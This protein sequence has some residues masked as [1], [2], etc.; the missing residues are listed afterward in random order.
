VLGGTQFLGKLFIEH[1][2]EDELKSVTMLNRGLSSHS[3]G[4]K[5]KHLKVDRFFNSESVAEVLKELV[6]IDVVVDFTGIHGFHV[7]D[8][9]QVLSGKIGHYIY[10]SCANVYYFHPNALRFSGMKF[11]ESR[12]APPEEASESAIGLEEL[13]GKD[14]ALANGKLS[15]ENFLLD[16]HEK[17]HFPVT[18]LRLPDV[19][20][21]MDN[22]GKH[23]HLQL[24]IKNNQKIGI[25]NKLRQFSVIYAND[26]I[27]A[28]NETIKEKDKVLGKILNI[29]GDEAITIQEYA[30]KVATLINAEKPS[31][32]KEKI[33]V[34][35]HIMAGA[36]DN[37]LAKKLLYGWVPTPMD[38]W[39]PKVVE[40]YN[41][42][43]NL[44]KAHELL[45]NI[46][47]AQLKK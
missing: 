37:S 17:H 32:N 6:Y 3:F 31:F 23:L 38:V 34:L 24:Q 9:V 12:L 5:V 28:I 18:I 4:D 29:A 14:L 41:E 47:L 30:S 33:G 44:K 13:F 11:Q 40:W 42:P 20:G 35:P 26:V 7:S 1:L 27:R 21:T 43:E 36:I 10:I 8:A 25:G 45:T 15:A 39:L 2:L 16:M 22:K 19:I 46:Q